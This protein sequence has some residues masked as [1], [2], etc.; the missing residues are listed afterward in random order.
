MVIIRARDI[1]EPITH[2]LSPE[3]TLKEAVNEMRVATRKPG[4]YGVKGMIVIDQEGR[5]AGMVAIKDILNALMP[6]YMSH[7]AVGEFAWPGMFEEMARK[8]AH[9][10]VSEIMSTKVTSV[11]P[12]T[13]VMECAR[14]IVK[15]NLWRL[16]VIDA[17]R[18]P[19]G[20]VY[21]RDLHYAIVKALFDG[22]EGEE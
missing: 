16:P 15:N 4:W 19:A 6:S 22:E 7:C 10:K 2:T 21:V 9:K 14:L 11:T 5:V 20:M 17:D 18:R 3:S 1:M 13:P 8:V 12:D